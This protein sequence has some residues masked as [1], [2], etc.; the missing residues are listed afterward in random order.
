M[1][2]FY[3]VTI[4]FSESHPKSSRRL[5][6]TRIENALLCMLEYK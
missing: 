3:M 6:K 1:V 4:W 5:N 2:F